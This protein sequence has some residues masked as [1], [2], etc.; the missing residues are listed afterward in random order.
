MRFYRHQGN[1]YEFFIDLKFRRLTA[2]KKILGGSEK[3]KTFCEPLMEFPKRHASPWRPSHGL[4]S[5]AKDAAPLNYW[6]SENLLHTKESSAYE[7]ILANV[8]CFWYPGK[9]LILD[10][11][12]VAID[13]SAGPSWES[14]TC[15]LTIGVSTISLMVWKNLNLSKESF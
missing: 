15:M 4:T 11:H 12:Q 1:C 9:V 2:R 8:F 10:H 3:P 6:Q 13:S 5:M 7:G 14:D